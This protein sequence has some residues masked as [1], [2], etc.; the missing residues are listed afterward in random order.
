VTT[1]AT[2]PQTEQRD[3]ALNW[4]VTQSYWRQFSPAEWV[5]F[6]NWLDPDLDPFD[7]DAVYDRLY[8]QD[9]KAEELL[10]EIAADKYWVDTAGAEP[11][12]LE[13]AK[14]D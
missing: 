7:L 6:V 12:D 5:E 13:F 11:T 3:V 10:G 4:T 14:D 1:S 8:R 9:W 2:E